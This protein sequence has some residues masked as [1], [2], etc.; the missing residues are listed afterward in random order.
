MPKAILNTQ[1]PAGVIVVER[2]RIESV[3]VSSMAEKRGITSYG[4]KH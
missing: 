1:K 4:R 3:G 2:Q